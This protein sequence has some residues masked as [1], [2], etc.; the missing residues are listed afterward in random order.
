MSQTVVLCQHS[1]DC[2]FWILN[3]PGSGLNVSTENSLLSV[4]VICCCK[5]G[6]QNIKQIILTVSFI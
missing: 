4:V 6:P 5:I 3:S 2:G 1:E